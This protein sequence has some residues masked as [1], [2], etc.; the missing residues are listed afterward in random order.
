MIPFTDSATIWKSSNSG[1]ISDGR[2][3]DAKKAFQ[4]SMIVSENKIC[5]LT[6]LWQSNTFKCVIAGWPIFS[7]RCDIFKELLMVNENKF[8]TFPYELMLF[9]CYAQYFM[10]CMLKK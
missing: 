7:K 3:E 10:N 8:C 6:K 2:D 4:A 1:N 9:N 5:P